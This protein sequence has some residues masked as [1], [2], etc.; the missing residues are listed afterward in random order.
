MK[1]MLGAAALVASWILLPDCGTESDLPAGQVGGNG[2]AGGSLST[3]GGTGSSVTTGTA[4]GSSATGSVGSSSATGGTAGAPGAGGAGGAP[5]VGGKGG[6]GGGKGG[7]RGLDA[8]SGSSSLP[9]CTGDPSACPANI[10][11][12]TDV[13]CRDNR[14]CVSWQPAGGSN[15]PR[16]L[17]CLDC[18]GDTDCPGNSYCRDGLCTGC[19]SDRDCPPGAKC[20]QATFEGPGPFVCQ[21]HP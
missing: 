8:G 21:R 3:T 7:T 13:F 17:R 5:P 4:G 10:V 20:E 14:C 15:F 16:Q 19:L 12:L 18:V 6:D 1:R 9:V 2:G 11:G